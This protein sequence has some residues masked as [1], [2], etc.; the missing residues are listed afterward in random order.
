[1]YLEETSGR[2]V[3]AGAIW[4][5]NL[6]KFRNK[7]SDYHPPF[8]GWGPWSPPECIFI[9]F[10]VDFRYLCWQKYT[11][12]CWPPCDPPA[13][14]HDGQIRDEKENCFCGICFLGFLGKDPW[15]LC[16][17]T[18]IFNVYF[19]GGDV[20]LRYPRLMYTFS[21]GTSKMTSPPPKYTLN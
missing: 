19:G 12:I 1:M 4:K 16:L 20:I 6:K 7:Y 15:N 3:P 8:L 21:R 18:Y 11:L 5:T 17:P 9:H 2:K 14:P 10:N 13:D